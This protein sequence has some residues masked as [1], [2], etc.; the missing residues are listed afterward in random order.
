M[1]YLF[2]LPVFLIN[3]TIWSQTKT[4]DTNRDFGFWAS[5]QISHKFNKKWTFRLEEQH[6]LKDNLTA[7]DR[8]LTQVKAEYNLSNQFRLGLGSRHLWLNDDI[9]NQQGFEHHFRLHLYA[10]YKT[11]I[12]SFFFYK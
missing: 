4:L 2:L 12:K 11:R 9:G 5:T 10:S 6:R 8:L 1:R 7:F 3:S